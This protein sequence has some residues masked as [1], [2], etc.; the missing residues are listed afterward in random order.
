VGV[1]EAAFRH[2]D[3]QFMIRMILH[4]IFIPIGVYLTSLK[5]HKENDSVVE[6][7]FSLISFCLITV[8]S[9]GLNI[10]ILELSN[11]IIPTKDH[12]HMEHIDKRMIIYGTCMVIGLVLQPFKTYVNK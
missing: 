4:F 1:F 8:G 5:E 12:S 3:Y 2:M 10:A 6:K 7:T 9:V 11:I